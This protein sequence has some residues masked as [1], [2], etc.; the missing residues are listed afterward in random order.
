MNKESD[1][2]AS[3]SAGM[4]A[5]TAQS[6]LDKSKSDDERA[7]RSSSRSGKFFIGGYFPPEVAKQMRILA[8]EQDSTIQLFTAE[9]L[10]HLF[11]AYGKPRIAPAKE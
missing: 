8:A 10:N 6:G 4:K 7:V 9:A 2:V 1:L 11:A 3:I 5:P